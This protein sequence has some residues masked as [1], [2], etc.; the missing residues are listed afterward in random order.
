MDKSENDTEKYKREPNCSEILKNKLF[1]HRGNNYPQHPTGKC[2][3][4]SIITETVKDLLAAPYMIWQRGEEMCP[5]FID[6]VTLKKMGGTSP[7][8]Y[9]LKDQVQ[10][11]HLLTQNN[12]EIPKNE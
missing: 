6:E 8:F 2:V 5:V 4:F 3:F 9:G 7:V 12:N 10:E 1:N 11:I